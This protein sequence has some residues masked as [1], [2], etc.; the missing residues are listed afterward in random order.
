MSTRDLEP[1]ELETLCEVLIRTLPGVPLGE[2]TA[3]ATMC[4]KAVRAAFD[5]ARPITARKSPQASD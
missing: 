1:I 4:A 3:V 2:M 5:D